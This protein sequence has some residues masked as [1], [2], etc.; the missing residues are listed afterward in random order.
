MTR[1]MREWLGGRRAGYILKGNREIAKDLKVFKSVPDMTHTK[2]FMS[3]RVS[4]EDIG[5]FLLHNTLPP[6]TELLVYQWLCEST[7]NH[8]PS[9]NRAK[10]NQVVAYVINHDNKDKAIDTLV[11]VMK[12]YQPSVNVREMAGQEEEAAG[13]YRELTQEEKDAFEADLAA[14]KAKK[15]ASSARR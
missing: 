7:V 9:F 10:L 15:A 11:K 12:T 6:N 1:F 2:I 5:K 8:K 14:Y 3:A 4:V 13:F